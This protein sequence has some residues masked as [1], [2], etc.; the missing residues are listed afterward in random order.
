MTENLVTIGRYSTPYEAHMVKSRLESEGI[1]A[2]IAD[3]YTIGINWLYS[4]ALGGVKVR[5]PA[6]LASEALQIL[7][8]EIEPSATYNV[9]AEACPECGSKNTEDFLD[10]RNSFLTWMLF[11]LPLLLPREKRRCK[12]CGHCWRPSK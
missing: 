11:G 4:N 3:E 12:E 2:F 5:V 8:P 1:P 9:E 7:A 6:P 10:K